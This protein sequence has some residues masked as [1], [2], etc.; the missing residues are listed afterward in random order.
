MTSSQLKRGEI[1]GLKDLSHH[2]GALRVD[3]SACT[4]FI[5]RDDG[6]QATYDLN[7][8]ILLQRSNSSII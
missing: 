6:Y 3:L 5:Q 4:V 8:G 7:S 2:D 1:A